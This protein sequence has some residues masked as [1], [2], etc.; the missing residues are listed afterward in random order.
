MKTIQ[1]QSAEL[2][3]TVEKIAQEIQ[4]LHVDQRKISVE[5]ILPPAGTP[6]ATPAGFPHWAVYAEKEQKFLGLIPYKKK[7]MICVVK[8]GFYDLQDSGR[9]DVLV[10]L[11]SNAAE[12]IIKKHLAE[13][14]QQ[15]Q[16][17]E[18]VYKT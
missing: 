1:T 6:T 16:V 10:L 14:A 12:P 4:L 17:T 5:R 8:E 18:V 9:K 2:K 15:N 11:K 3:L 7:T 13:Y